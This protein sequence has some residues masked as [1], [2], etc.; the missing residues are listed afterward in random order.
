MELNRYHN[1]KESREMEVREET[2][3]R[4]LIF[5]FTYFNKI[6]RQWKYLYEKKTSVLSDGDWSHT[7]QIP[8]SCHQAMDLPCSRCMVMRTKGW[9]REK[10]RK[11]MSMGRKAMTIFSI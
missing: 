11:R 4:H 6:Y 9:K 2:D 1:R 8:G 7:N 10:E 3:D 5:Y